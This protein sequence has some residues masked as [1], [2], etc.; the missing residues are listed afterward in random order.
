MTPA[1]SELCPVHPTELSVGICGRTLA[2]FYALVKM[3]NVELEPMRWREP[4][5]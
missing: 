3:N 1:T 5:R 2:M 4:A